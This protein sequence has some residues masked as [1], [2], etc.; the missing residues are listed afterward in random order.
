MGTSIFSNPSVIFDHVP[1][2]KSDFGKYARRYFLVDIFGRRQNPDPRL[3][4]ASDTAGRPFF[5]IAPLRRNRTSNFALIF[6]AAAQGPTPGQRLGQRRWQHLGQRP[7]HHGATPAE[8]ILPKMLPSLKKSLPVQVKR[9][10]A[11]MKLFQGSDQTH[12]PNGD[13]NI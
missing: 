7:D 10:L 4:W 5:F 8:S 12:L 9:L 6:G 1:S 2:H 11:K 13:L 3:A